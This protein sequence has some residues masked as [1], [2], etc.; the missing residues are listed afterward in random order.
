MQLAGLPI[1]VSL[2]PLSD[3]C[4]FSSRETVAAGEIPAKTSHTLNHTVFEV[5]KKHKL[6]HLG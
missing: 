1:L 3:G 6:G 2:L 5:L 4:N